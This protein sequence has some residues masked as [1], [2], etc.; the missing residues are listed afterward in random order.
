MSLQSLVSKKLQLESKWADQCLDQGQVTVEMKWIDI[1]LKE[2][3]R[4]IN[5]Q[6][7]IDMKVKL[8]KY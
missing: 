8:E 6:S 4:K 7:V 3:K 1:E 2:L 5:E